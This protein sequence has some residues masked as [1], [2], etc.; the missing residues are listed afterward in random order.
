M[1]EDIT[2]SADIHYVI[3]RKL[4]DKWV[5]VFSTVF[6]P[7]QPMIISIPDER[8]DVSAD[9]T[10][11]SFRERNYTL[12]AALAQVR[13]G[14][15]DSKAGQKPKG[16]PG[17]ISD[18]AKLSVDDWGSDGHSHTW[19]PMSEFISEWIKCDEAMAKAAVTEKISPKGDEIRPFIDTVIDTWDDEL[20][21][22]RIVLWFDN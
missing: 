18:L 5:G 8:L 10:F 13:S 4:G 3:E 9:R 21:T 7:R 1:K 19:F 14:D 16:L 2:L 20:D 17:D 6:T 11:L 15:G 12:F 22:L